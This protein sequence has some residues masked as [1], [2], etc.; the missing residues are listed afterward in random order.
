M[1]AAQHGAAQACL[2]WHPD[3]EI[4]LS[5]ASD[6]CKPANFSS[7]RVFWPALGER[8]GRWCEWLGFLRATRRNESSPVS[9]FV[10]RR[11]GER[12]ERDATLRGLRS[13]TA[14][15]RRR[16]AMP[17]AVLARSRFISAST[18]RPTSSSNLDILRVKD[19]MLIPGATKI[20]KAM[21]DKRAR[22]AYDSRPCMQGNR[23][24]NRRHDPSEP[25]A[26]CRFSGPPADAWAN[27]GDDSEMTRTGARRRGNSG[28]E[29]DRQGPSPAK[30][31]SR[32]GTRAH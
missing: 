22:P 5:A 18:A 24:G 19:R 25:H 4:Q 8:A 15:A 30:E 13:L 29:R 10:A 17:G 9:C 2:G 21:Q 28:E 20:D 1:R 16:A 14:A 6:Q 12:Q 31:M 7:L 27:K 3:C 23:R 11:R 32:S 26:A